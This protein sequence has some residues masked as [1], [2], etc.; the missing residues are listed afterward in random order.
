MGLELVFDC[1]GHSV[2]PLVLLCHLCD[3]YYITQQTVIRFERA[4]QE[5]SVLTATERA[6]EEVTQNQ[7]STKR[8]W[9]KKG[10]LA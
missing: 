6:E 7:Q 2:G 10:P 3:Q 8:W 1:R 5:R 9:V 4:I